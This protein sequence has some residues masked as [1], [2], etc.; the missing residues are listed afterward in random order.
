MK[1]KR[2]DQRGSRSFKAYLESVA[3]SLKRTHRYL[4][5]SLLGTILEHKLL[6]LELQRSTACDIAR[7]SRHCSKCAG[8]TGPAPRRVPVP[9]GMVHNVI[10]ATQASGSAAWAA[11]FAEI[12]HRLRTLSDAAGDHVSLNNFLDGLSEED[13]Y[14]VAVSVGLHHLFD[15][16]DEVTYPRWVLETMLLVFS[17]E[18]P[19]ANTQKW[20]RLVEPSSDTCMVDPAAYRQPSRRSSTK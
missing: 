4:L 16:R 5:E 10:A 14:D 20:R 17:N 9:W 6:Q 11:T 1:L 18:Y 12:E 2:E 8:T 15:E 19:R 13:G 7:N 3:P